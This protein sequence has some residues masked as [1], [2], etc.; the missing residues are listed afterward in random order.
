MI[1]YDGPN[2]IGTYANILSEQMDAASAR[3]Y[4]EAM[5]VMAGDLNAS[6]A[7]DAI[8]KSSFDETTKLRALQRMNTMI[9]DVAGGQVMDV[10]MPFESENSITPERL[11]TIMRYKTASYSFMAPMQ[12][13]AIMAGASPHTLGEIAKLAEPMGMAYQVTDDILGI[14]GDE[15]ETGKSSTSD[16]KEGKRTLL[17]E[18][19]LM[20]ASSK[21][22]HDLRNCLGVEISESQH[23]HVKEILKVCGALERATEQAKHYAEQAESHLAHV[24]FSPDATTALK[25][26]SSKMSRRKK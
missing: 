18:Y 22:K 8:I 19:G 1:R 15:T 5:S 24:G 4:A 21:Q 25:D 20:M 16:L 7:S 3:R 17:I 23:A 26:L 12:L 14:F 9:F 6:F 10:L 13:G 2:I 11:E